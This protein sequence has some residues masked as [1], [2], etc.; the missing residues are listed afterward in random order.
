[1]SKIAIITGALGGIGHD[2]CLAFQREGYTVIGLARSLS[3]DLNESFKLIETEL[4]SE[5]SVKNAIESI[6]QDYGHIDVLFNVAGGSGRRFGDGP[7]DEC[8]EEGFDKTIDL[9]LK[10]QFFT[11]K[12]VVKQMMKQESGCILNLT[13]VLGMTGGGEYFATHTYA[14]TKAAIIGL[15]KAMAIQY[16]KYNIRVNAIAPGLIETPMSKR[17]QSDDEILEY[18]KF[19]QPV[20]Q[21]RNTLGQPKSISKAATFLASDDADFIT[22]IVLPVDG[23]WTAR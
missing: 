1:M 11:C 12:Y 18:M 8:T 10:T 5:E 15:S 2:S 21:N 9:N 14:A 17:A 3:D 23:G 7:I 16:A 6:V 4:T 13:S 19:M 22:G 20:Y